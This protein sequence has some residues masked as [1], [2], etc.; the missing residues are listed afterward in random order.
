MVQNTLTLVPVVTIVS[1][2]V[3]AV[4]EDAAG[5]ERNSNLPHEKHCRWL[6]NSMLTSY[7]NIKT[8]SEWSRFQGCHTSVASTISQSERREGE[9]LRVRL[10]LKVTT[11]S[12]TSLVGEAT[13]SKRAAGESIALTSSWSNSI[14]TDLSSNCKRK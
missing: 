4:T 14:V 10:T 12:P 13:N 7:N 8:A 6:L 5:T 3:V 2:I 11:I 9:H 1:G